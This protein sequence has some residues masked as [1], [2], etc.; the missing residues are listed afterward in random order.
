M[1]SA[2]ASEMPTLMLIRCERPSTLTGWS[3]VARTRSATARTSWGSASCGQSTTNSSPP[4]L[5]KESSG[6]TAARILPG[7]GNQQLVAH[8]VPTCVV[9]HLEAVEVQEDHGHV[10][11]AG[12]L[13]PGQPA[14]AGARHG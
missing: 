8:L 14:D 3:R 6:R 2:L 1:E 4:I 7:N 5:A 9:D 12:L 11:T 10:R 13:R